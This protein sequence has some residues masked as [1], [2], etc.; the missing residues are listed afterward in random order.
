MSWLKNSPLRASFGKLRP[1]TSPPKDCDPVACYESFKKHWQQTH[2][3]I[4]RTQPPAGYPIQDDVLGVVNHLDQMANLLLL[5]LRAGS[6][7]QAPCLEF[8]L[9]ENLLDC[10]FRWS[11]HTGRYA[12]AVRLQQLKLYELLLASCRSQ[13]LSHEPLVRPLLK[14]LASCEGECLPVELERRLVVLL[15]QLCVSL[16]HNVELLDLFFCAPAGPGPGPARFVIFTLLIPFVHREGAIGQQARDA[17]LLCM[18]LSKKNGTVGA[19]I[20][21]RSNVCPVLATGLSG[22]YSVL[23]RKLRAEAD[24]WHRLTPDDVAAVPELAAF[25]NSLEFCNAV[26][27]VAHPRVTA[28]LL[29][30]LH[31]GFLVPVVGPA[32]L[33]NS[34]EELVTATA[35]FDLFLRSISEPGLLYSFIRFLLEDKYD[36]ERIL[37]C[38]INRIDAKTR[39]CLVTL[40]LF[41]TLVDL[42][43]EDV[44]LELVLKYLVPCTHVMLSQR[45]R[46]RDVEPYCRSSDKFLTLSPSCCSQHHLLPPPPSH[47]VSPS[48]SLPAMHRRG[49]PADRGQPSSLPACESLYGNYHAYLCSARRQIKDCAAACSSWAYRYDGEDPSPGDARPK[50]A[51]EPGSDAA[52]SNR[53]SLDGCEDES[54]NVPGKKEECNDGKTS[55]NTLQSENSSEIVN[56]VAASDDHS[57]LSDRDDGCTDSTDVADKRSREQKQESG[58]VATTRDDGQGA[59]LP[60]EDVANATA[61]NYHSLPSIGES[62]GY[63]SFAP[64]GSP[65]ST[66]ENE[67]VDEDQGVCVSEDH[68]QKA[69]GRSESS[70]S[71]HFFAR[72]EDSWSLRKFSKEGPNTYL[73]IFNTTPDIGPFLDVVL[74]RL[75]CMMLND[76]YVNLHLTGLVSRLAVY[77]QPLLHS[78]LLNHSLVFQ[79][80]IRSL[81]QVLGSLKH[82]IDS[83]LNRQPNV[84]ELVMSAQEFLL[85]RED[86]I[87]NARRNAVEASLANAPNG[88]RNSLSTDSFTRGESKRR[89]FTSTLSSVFRRA[90]QQPIQE[91][92]LETVPSGAGYRFVARA[93]RAVEAG[94]CDAGSVAMCAV[95]LDEWLKELAA[96][97][98]EQAMFALTSGWCDNEMQLFSCHAAVCA[99]SCRPCD[100]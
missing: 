2:D 15:N 57:L 18:A 32:L 9:S 87:V 88:R 99:V 81:F 13:L 14:L 8:L 17:L 85:A 100:S 77:P 4:Q 38:L 60:G 79:P 22:L 98:Q 10:L 25:M 28:Q 48:P 56:V 51:G 89:S 64:K 23:P 36:G 96:V 54:R 43:C 83:Y 21:D 95:L 62:S 67:P 20:A 34:V 66:P 42:N 19:Y 53:L 6:E 47:G 65:E 29:E 97:T 70:S 45:R 92:R 49:S 12:N 73:D 11:V 58:V 41:E 71:R 3:I 69:R 80:S 61:N 91:S 72:P 84:E 31:Q 46:V 26:V 24:D 86:K 27:Q 1:S 63:E 93:W 16:A 75:E 90:T 74:R 82:R 39:L 30:F 40:A 35:Y 68:Q 5:D 52:T 76:V 7:G 37:D 33:Q 59:E 94:A 55:E 78:F 44:M 50:R